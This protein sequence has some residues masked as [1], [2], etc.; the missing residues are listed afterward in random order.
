[1][2]VVWISVRT[3]GVNEN[4]V[5][6]QYGIRCQN[7]TDVSWCILHINTGIIL[8]GRWCKVVGNWGE[9][10]SLLFK[11][12]TILCPCQC[13]KQTWKYTGGISRETVLGSNGRCQVWTGWCQ[14]WTGWCQVW[15]G[16]CHVWTGW[17]HVWTGWCQVWTGWCQVWTVWQWMHN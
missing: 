3:W 7:M 9:V 16:W 12:W 15:T 13:I 14:V 6:V 2:Q 4:Y 1:M 10:A 8:L 17:C 11:C 5:F